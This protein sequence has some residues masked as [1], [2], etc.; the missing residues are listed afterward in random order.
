[1]HHIVGHAWAVKRLSSAIENNQLAQSHLFVGPPHI[2]KSALAKAT[3]SQLLSRNAKDPARTTQLVET[4]RHP[5]LNWLEAEGEGAT[6]SIKVE[7]IRELLHALSLSPVEGHQRVAVLNDAHLVTESG[8]NAILKTLEEP[9]PSVVIILIAPSVDT[10][11]P[12]ISSRCQILNLRPVPISQV[13]AALQARGI[14]A[15]QAG[16]VARLSRGRMGWAI[17][18]I[19]DETVLAE[20]KERLDQLQDLLAANRTQRFAFAEKL[21]RADGPEIQ[22]MLE[23]WTLFWRDVV[24]QQHANNGTRAPL[25]NSDYGSAITRAAERNPLPAVAATLRTLAQTS[26]HLQQNVNARLALDVLML[27]LP[28]A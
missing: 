1:M 6:R 8:K 23:E 5:D 24:Q 13:S 7:T 10:V 20:R 2:G 19:E 15:S 26:Q 18:A 27:K 9:N 14:E 28:A 21:A 25:R 11:L 4:L 16:F 12:T 17:R 22:A 3:A